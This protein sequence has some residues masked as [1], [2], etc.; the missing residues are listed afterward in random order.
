MKDPNQPLHND[1]TSFDDVIKE[2][3]SIIEWSVQNNSRIGFFAAIYKN[4]TVR[5]KNAAD[6]GEFEDKVRIEK[7]DVTFAKRYFAAI[8]DYR[9]NLDVVPAWTFTLRCRKQVLPIM[10]IAYLSME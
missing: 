6:A 8:D 2:L 4:M 9:N 7:L 5:I 3:N 1:I 10:I